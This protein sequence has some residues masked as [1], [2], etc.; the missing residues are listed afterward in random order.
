MKT[1]YLNSEV[2][3]SSSNII[4]STQDNSFSSIIRYHNEEHDTT[5]SDCANQQNQFCELFIKSI[6]NLL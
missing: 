5:F 4:S 1:F 3:S 2:G 6:L